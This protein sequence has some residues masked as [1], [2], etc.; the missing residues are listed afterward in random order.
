MEWP[1][2][3]GKW[4]SFP[5]IDRAEWISLERGVVKITKGQIPILLTLAKK[6]GLAIE[7]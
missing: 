2:K 3:S 1:P 6:L 4:R 5:E 7:P